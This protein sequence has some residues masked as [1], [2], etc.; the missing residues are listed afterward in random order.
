M[1]KDNVRPLTLTLIPTVIIW[2]LLWFDFLPRYE[3]GPLT[4]IMSYFFPLVVAAGYA[5]FA[6]FRPILREYAA[7]ETPEQRA[8]RDSIVA[9][10]VRRRRRR[11]H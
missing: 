2:G 8:W 9:R 1:A 4:D 11:S 5:I 6:I 3:R 10:D 7:N